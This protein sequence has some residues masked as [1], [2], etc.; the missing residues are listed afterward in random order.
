MFQ[1]VNLAYDNVKEVDCLDVSKEG[2]DSWEAAVK[3][4]VTERCFSFL[5]N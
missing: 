1:E 3:R 5:R 4:F 2:M